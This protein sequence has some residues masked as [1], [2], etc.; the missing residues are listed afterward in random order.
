MQLVIRQLPGHFRRWSAEHRLA[1]TPVLTACDQIGGRKHTH[2]IVSLQIRR[3]G[4]SCDTCHLYA[5][6]RREGRQKG[7]AW[8]GLAGPP[9]SNLVLILTGRQAR[10][11]PLFPLAAAGAETQSRAC[12]ST[13][14]CQPPYTAAPRPLYALFTVSRGL[15]LRASRDTSGMGSS[16]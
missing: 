8:V 14:S 11:T 5:V 16:R 6:Q 4:V 7:K 1:R 13:F 9:T 3:H 2:T 10:L 15:D 12:H